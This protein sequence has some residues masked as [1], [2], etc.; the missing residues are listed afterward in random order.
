MTKSKEE[1]LLE[2]YQTNSINPCIIPVEDEKVWEDHRIKRQNLYRHLM[3]PLNYFR[4]K[5]IL[6]FGCNSGENAL[7]LASIGACLTL[8]E[9]NNQVIPRLKKIFTHFKLEQ[10]ITDIYNKDITSYSDDKRYNMVVAE[11]FLH[12]LKNRERMLLK[13]GNMLV[14]GGLAIISYDDKY[15]SMLEMIKILL[16]C[17]LCQIRNVA[18]NSDH[19]LKLANDLFREDFKQLNAS[20]SF[21]SWWEDNLVNSHSSF[22]A[23][24]SFKEIINVITQANCS[25]Y[26][27]SPRWSN[28]DNY[29]WHKNVLTENERK[30]CLNDEWNNNFLFFLTGL[31]PK[32][33]INIAPTQTVISAVEDLI[34]M[35][36][37]NCFS[38]QGNIGM[39]QYPEELERYMMKTNNPDVMLLNQSLKSLFKTIHTNDCETIIN[40]YHSL[41]DLRKMWGTSLHYIC[42]SKPI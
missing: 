7:Y 42:F 30:Q 39:I 18:L 40:H 3:I 6:E 5:S 21:K 33:G 19:S 27:S 17:R 15:G 4:N 35:I 14:P 38:R 41:R 31:Q 9:P 10:N 36:S 23:F 2:Y 26:S 1:S 12:T 28:I 34:K 32:G 24:W 16:L 22:Q 11:G 20:R 8:Y 25:F 29:T 37:E 13:I